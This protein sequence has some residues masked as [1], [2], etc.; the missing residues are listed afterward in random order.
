[1]KIL[2]ND[3]KSHQFQKGQTGN[4]E[5]RLRL[6]IKSPGMLQRIKE[7]VEIETKIRDISNAS[8]N[9]DII[10]ARVMYYY[11]ARKYTGFS[12]NEIGEQV[13]KDH[14]TAV[15]GIKCYNN[16]NFAV[17][18]YRKQLA[19]LHHIEQLVPEIKQEDIEPIDLHEL[20][21]ARNIALNS[22]ITKLLK[23]IREKDAK[24]KRLGGSIT[25]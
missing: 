7:L 15:Y 17:V 9:Q 12:F 2:N 13:N 25:I 20:F 16:W 22:Q 6:K 5:G 24:I 10:D 8:R 14:S 11:L 18:Q 21:R 23:E 3:I 4:P 19:Q 1:M